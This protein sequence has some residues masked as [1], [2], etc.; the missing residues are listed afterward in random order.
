VKGTRCIVKEEKERKKCVFFDKIVLSL[1]V[2]RIPE[3]YIEK[4]DDF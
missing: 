4:K 1:L 2:T 3:I